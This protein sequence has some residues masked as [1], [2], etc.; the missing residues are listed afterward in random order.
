MAMIFKMAMVKV[1]QQVILSKIRQM[2]SVK[3]LLEVLLTNYSKTL[4]VKVKQSNVNM[5]Q[6]AVSVSEHLIHYL[7]LFLILK[8]N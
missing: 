6:I 3:L 1:N 2:L 7:I 5:R 4:S 8:S